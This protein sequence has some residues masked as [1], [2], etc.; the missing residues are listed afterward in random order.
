MRETF[1]SKKRWEDLEKKVAD[2]EKQVQ[3]QPLEISKMVLQQLNTE[4]KETIQKF[5]Y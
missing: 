2:L 4:L 3:S 5:H 1:I